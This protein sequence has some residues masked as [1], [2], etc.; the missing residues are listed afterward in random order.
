LGLARCQGGSS[1]LAGKLLPLTLELSGEG[2]DGLACPTIR[3]RGSSTGQG[4]ADSRVGGW[5]WLA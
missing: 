2:T 3:A 4:A 1:L 5:A